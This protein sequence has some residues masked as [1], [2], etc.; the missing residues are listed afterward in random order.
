MGF[1]TEKKAL[2]QVQA[3]VHTALPLGPYDP[4]DMM[5]LEVPVEVRVALWGL[6]QAPLAESQKRPLGLW[7]MSV[8]SPYS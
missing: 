5:M 6:Q 4:E 8:S 1:R 2:Q 3:D 7:S